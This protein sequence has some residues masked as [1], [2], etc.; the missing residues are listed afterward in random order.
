MAR[1]V[2]QSSS[3]SSSIARTGKVLG[4]PAPRATVAARPVP[5]I[6][7]AMIARRAYEIWQSGQGAGELADWLRAER[8]LGGR[9]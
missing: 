5:A 7:H 1:K 9:R 4:T 2:N 6:T 8:E 3:Q